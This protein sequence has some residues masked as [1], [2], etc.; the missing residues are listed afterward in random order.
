MTHSR[1]LHSH[2]SSNGQ[3]VVRRALLCVAI[4]GALLS[5]H[6]ASHAAA[7]GPAATGAEGSSAV[8][9]DFDRSLLSGSG[10]NTNDLSRFERGNVIMPGVYRT[11]IYLNEVWVGRADVRFASPTPDAPVQACV[12]KALF[13]Q[14][15]L[16]LQ[17]LSAEQ[18]AKLADGSAACVAIG[19]LIDAA[20]INFDQPN[21]RL[22]AS[23]PQAWMGGHARG[24]VSP[25]NWDQGVNAGL[26]NYNANSYR[27]HSNG[28]TQTSSFLGLNAGI[29]IDG[30]QLR[31]DSTLVVQ[32]GAAGAGTQSH[33]QNLDTYIRHDVPSL[34]A[35]LTVGDSY[36]PGDLFDSI[37]VRGA[38]LTTDDRMLPDS[39]R[40]YAP[41]VR[42]VAETNAKVTVR[43]NGAVLYE[44]TVAPGPFVISDLYATGYGGDLV[45]NVTEADG[46]VRTFTVP[47]ASVPQLL[48]PGVYR[49][50]LVAG[51]LHDLNFHSNPGVVEATVQRGFNNLITGYAGV[52]GT[53]GYDAVQIGTAL[54]TRFGAI[55]VDLT[56]A[57]TQIPGQSTQNG[58]SVRLSYSKILPDTN[59]SLSVATYRYSTSGYLGLRDALTLQDIARG[60]RYVDP[61]TLTTIDG[62]STTNLLTPAQLAAL[63]GSNN[64]NFSTY[65]SQLDR[66]RS[67]FDITM[68]QRLGTRGGSFYVTGSAID[69]WNR[70]G[71]DVQFQAGYNN[72]FH[73]LSYNLSVTRTRDAYSRMSNELYASFTLPLGD[74][75][76]A[77]NFSASFT[78][79][80][81]GHTLD[82]AGINGTLGQ[83]NQFSYG[84][85]ASHDNGQGTGASGGNAGTVYAGY[86]SPF[87]QFNGSV[88]SGNGYSQSSVGVSGMV[89]VHPGGI[90][91]GLPAGDTVAIVE[92]KNAEGARILNSAGVRVDRFGYA[93]IPYMTPYNLNTVQIDPKGLPLN[94]QL[95]AT[96][97]QVAPH[98]GSVVMVKFKT[99][100]GRTAVLRL[101]RSDEQ[102]MPF[103]ADVLDEQGQSVGVVGQGGMALV[104]GVQDTG[105]LKVQWTLD[106]SA[107]MSCGFFYQLKPVT[108]GDKNK[109][110]ETVNAT[111]TP[112]ADSRS[113]S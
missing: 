9:A 42:G 47:Y 74:A 50:S 80:S 103:G 22:D 14:M 96:S 104:R 57:R 12:T 90:T 46:R 37:S 25:E 20:T 113:S 63:Q 67:R 73:R 106:D 71:T 36:T 17:K 94:V 60:Y 49:F 44:T 38:Q 61:T 78:H 23:I 45:V 98:A 29:N 56:D 16:P 34:R 72:S 19:E 107:P 32:S 70:N 6:G 100:Y 43:Q 8:E 93:L 21:L 27:N 15:G 83:D 89:V 102:P 91:F 69:Y 109:T 92:A 76:H 59:T 112:V 111:C 24:Y 87:A 11:D 53:N 10:N 79:D 39:M 54:N 77:P 31:H 75:V 86:R 26:L 3:T 68:N 18:Q 108:K 85:T 40:G 13:G 33:W 99:S 62:V 81:T 64:G 105:K 35:Q 28:I 55:A 7:A 110:V 51:E 52:V 101:R 65:T 84:A 88:G 1:A 4:G 97:S 30:W 58:Q 82:Q 5:W 41:T 2:V 66:Q 48:R 95:D